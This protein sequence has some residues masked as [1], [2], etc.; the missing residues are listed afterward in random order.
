MLA[1]MAQTDSSAM[2][3]DIKGA[4]LKSSID[5][6]RNEKLCMRLPSGEYMILKKYLY[7]LKQSGLE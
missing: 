4:Y 2:V 1:L 6:Q 3:I 5:K 7:G